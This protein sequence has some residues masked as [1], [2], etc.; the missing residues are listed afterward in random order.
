MKIILEE[1]KKI[2]SKE[3]PPEINRVLTALSQKNRQNIVIFL[4]HNNKMSFSDLMK[5]TNLKSSTLSFH[6][7]KLMHA[8]LIDNFYIKSGSSDRAYSY[9]ELTE[10]CKDFLE[11]FRLK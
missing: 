11:S 2:E 1:I 10:F 6:L 4:L 8:S 9:Y 5:Y 3:F 7:K